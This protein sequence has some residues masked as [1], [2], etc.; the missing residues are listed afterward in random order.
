[1]PTER[2][3]IGKTKKVFY[4]LAAPFGTEDRQLL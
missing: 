3:A 4:S 2:S 1:V